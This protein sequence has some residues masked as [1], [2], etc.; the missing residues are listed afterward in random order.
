M[1]IYVDERANEIHCIAIT[2]ICLYS[3]TLC[4]YIMYRTRMYCYI[5]LLYINAMFALY[6]SIFDLQG[7]PWCVYT[8]YNAVDVLYHGISAFF[9]TSMCQ[10]VLQLSISFCVCLFLSVSPCLSHTTHSMGRWNERY[11]YLSASGM[12]C[13]VY[14]CLHSPYIGSLY[15]VLWCGGCL[16]L[17]FCYI[18]CCCWFL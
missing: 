2:L 1:G 6:V 5:W 14:R 13:H 18:M 3:Q 4:K 12:Q 16:L 10:V 8:I 11:L 9:I 15:H 7:M 17:L